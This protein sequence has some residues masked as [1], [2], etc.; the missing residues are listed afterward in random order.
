MATVKTTPVINISA[1]D[2]EPFMI[3]EEQV[4]EVHWLRTESGGE[5]VLYTGLWRCEP[6]DIPYVFPGDETFQVLE[7][8]VR[9]EPEDGEPVQLKVGD[10]ASFPKGQHALWTIK[11]PFKKFFVISG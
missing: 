2:F 8:E 7:G 1:E 9:I 6:R 3:G 11:S 10:I 5:G 4:G